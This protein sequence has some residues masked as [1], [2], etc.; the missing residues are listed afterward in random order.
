MDSFI[1]NGQFQCFFNPFLKGEITSILVS[2]PE[3][4]VLAPHDY[5]LSPPQQLWMSGHER[6]EVE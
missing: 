2:S 4:T 3:Q 5:Q 1:I 6:E